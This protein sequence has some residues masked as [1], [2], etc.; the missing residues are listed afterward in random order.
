MAGQSPDLFRRHKQNDLINNKRRRL[1][2]GCHQGFMSRDTN[3]IARAEFRCLVRQR[4]Q[5]AVI[6]TESYAF[7]SLI[8]NFTGNG[9]I[10]LL[11]K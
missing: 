1:G 10:I 11:Y 9:E 2:A 8:G 5:C 7:L 6:G 4:I 3:L